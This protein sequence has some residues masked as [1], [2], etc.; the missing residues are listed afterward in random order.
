MSEEVLGRLDSSSSAPLPPGHHSGGGRGSTTHSHSHS[1]A[2]GS[3]GATG[4]NSNSK[5]ADILDM[6]LRN[7]EELHDLHELIDA[8]KEFDGGGVPEGGF[9][10]SHRKRTPFENYHLQDGSGGGGGGATSPGKEN[11]NLPALPTVHEQPA[12]PKTGAGTG[13]GTG[14]GAGAGTEEKKDSSSEPPP[15]AQAL[16]AAESDRLSALAHENERL[17]REIGTFDAEF[18]EQ[19]EDLKY[20]YSR[21]QEIVGE[22]P[23]LA[24]GAGGAGGSGTL[25]RT[26][27]GGVAGSVLPLDRL[28][29]AV[30]SSMTAMDRAGLTSPLVSRPRHTNAYTYAPGSSS[31]GGGRGPVGGVI[32]ASSTAGMS[33]TRLH[34]G[35]GGGGGG[36]GSI[37]S[38]GGGGGGRPPSGSSSSSSGQWARAGTMQQGYAAGTALYENRDVVDDFAA[39]RESYG[40]STT[41]H[42]LC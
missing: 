21:L 4:D 9:S 3:G 22:S 24:A 23:D 10:S 37:G 8:E 15:Q 14:A 30:R 17:K 7:L 27:A 12:A 1:H 42:A 5:T 19:L 41:S 35:G 31:G 29:W 32:P 39:S 13:T 16:S 2:L 36:V 26:G 20:R 34:G 11:R 6:S 40:T 28:S 38:G 33:R 25:Q 18:F